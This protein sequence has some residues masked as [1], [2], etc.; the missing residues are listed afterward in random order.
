MEGLIIFLLQD[1]CC[2]HRQVGTRDVFFRPVV[3]VV[4]A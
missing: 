1:H 2:V 3:F 4:D